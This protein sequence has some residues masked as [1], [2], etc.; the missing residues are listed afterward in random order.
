MLSTQTNALFN[1]KYGQTPKINTN[2]SQEDALLKQQ[3]DQFE[4]IFVQKV[5]DISLQNESGLFPKTAGSDIYQ[6]MY[7]QSLSESMTGSFGFS[8]LLFNFLKENHK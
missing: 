2:L 7:N 8:E 6:S 1:Y 5:L 3:T 4:A